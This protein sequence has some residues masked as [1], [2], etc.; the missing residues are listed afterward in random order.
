MTEG[1][2][3]HGLVTRAQSGFFRVETAQGE[4]V[5]QLRGRLTQ[6]RLETDV[7]AAGDRVRIELQENG[8]ATIEEVE[9][10]KRVLSRKAPGRER[11]QVIVANPDQVILVFACAEPDP[12]FRMLDRL[13]VATEREAIPTLICANKVDLV[14]LRSARAEFGEYE[15]LNYPVHYTSAKTGRGVRK[16]CKALKGKLSVFAGPSGA[17]KSSLLNAIQP[18]LGLRIG[19]IS[20]SSGKGK[21][22]TVAPEL[23]PLKQGGYVADTPG[24]KSLALW[25]IEPEELDAYFREIAPLVETC[26][27]S[28]CT[29]V[30]EPGCAV[31]EA[32]QRG[33]ISPE[34]YESYLRM[35]LGEA[36]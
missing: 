18:G 13:L 9:E 7:I 5:A 16:L 30:H 29:H 34:R 20:A 14:E 31:M 21:H 1:D 26:E 4:F 32:L 3:L 35:R 28:D 25:D 2:H 10:R 33:D 19:A 17:G 27:F 24:I 15:N 22:T 36:D 11:E 6:E 23:V 12:N 8:K